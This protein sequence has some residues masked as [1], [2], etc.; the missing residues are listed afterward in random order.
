M[1][2]RVLW[3]LTSL[4]FWRFWEIC[5]SVYCVSVLSV[6]IESTDSMIGP[7]EFLRLAKLYFSYGWAAHAAR[8]QVDCYANIFVSCVQWCGLTVAVCLG[9]LFEGQPTVN[10]FGKQI[11]KN[12]WN[13]LSYIWQFSWCHLDWWNK[14]SD[15][16]TQAI[17][18]PQSRWAT[19]SKAP[20]R[21]LSEGSRLGLQNALLAVRPCWWT[22]V[23]ARPW[24]KM[25]G[26][27]S[28][29]MESTGGGHHLNVGMLIPLK[30]CGMV[31]IS[32]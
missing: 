11:N 5:I 23:H 29:T 3:W 8:W 18:L 19:L 6:H 10:L 32:L 26:H 16:I 28:K 21:T 22:Q 14:R 24:P 17:L 30:T 9:G 7:K 25:L 12:V 4:L 20:P 15:A 2:G 31:S 1:N 13:G 27:S